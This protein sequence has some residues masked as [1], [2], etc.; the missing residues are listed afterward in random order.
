MVMNKTIV[1][2]FCKATLTLPSSTRRVTVQCPRCERDFEPADFRLAGPPGGEWKATL[3]IALLAGNILAFAAQLVINLT[4]MSL[5][6]EVERMQLDFFNVGF[7]P[8]ADLMDRWDYWEGVSASMVG[9]I[10]F[11][12]VPTAIGFFIW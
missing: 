6:A 2:P 10:V 9:L 12:M 3:A 7:P 8:A 1:C 11:I 5:A 4:R